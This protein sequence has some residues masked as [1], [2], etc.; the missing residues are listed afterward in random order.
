MSMY[1]DGGTYTFVKN[2]K[3]YYV[4]RRIGSKTRDSI[5]DRYPGDVGAKIVKVTPP[6]S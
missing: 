5:Y 6:K 3:T 4:D 1:K 2:G